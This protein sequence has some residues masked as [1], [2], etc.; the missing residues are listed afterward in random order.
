M[1]AQLDSFL[2]KYN[3]LSK[4][5]HGF[6]TGSSTTT[7]LHEFYERLLEHL[8]LGE[9]PIALLCDL[10]RA[11]DCVDPTTLL[12]TLESIS[13]RGPAL[14][15]FESYLNDR[16]QFVKLTSLQNNIL[17][18]S[19]SEILST[20]L[21]V[22]QGSVLG[23]KL[24]IIYIDGISHFMN[25]KDTT[26]YVDDVTVLKSNKN[27]GQLTVEINSTLQTLNS[28]FNN[29]NLYFNPTKTKYITFHTRQR[30]NI[31]NLEIKLS[32]TQLEQ[33][34]SYKLLG[35]FFDD[36]LTFR[37][38]CDYLRKLLNSICFQIRVL[39]TVFGT[40]ELVNFY[41]A[42]VYSRLVYGITIW[43]TSSAS[44]EIF[45]IQKRIVRTILGAPQTQSCRELFKALN[46][47]PLA[48]ILI[49]EL[50]YYAHTNK[51]KFSKHLDVHSHLTRNREK[52]L[53]PYRR[54]NLSMNEHNILGCRLYN[55]LP[56]EF[57]IIK[58]PVQFR[59]LVTRYLSKISPYTIE[60]YFSYMST[61]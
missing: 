31:P 13:V 36:Q 54:L 12:E 43:G 39:K 15:W 17:Q 3:I 44:A 19:V 22:P 16:S 8:E 51:S 42:Y 60:E 29:N 7:A 4:S 45:L 53:I 47:L 14:K 2:N 1:L 38:H 33:V 55:V 32:D 37:I 27:H 26:L 40:P 28:W 61:E 18:T 5:Q 46:I 10:S 9:C 21:G 59:K 25:E 24:F 49:R 52:L 50:L 56:K 34:S 11:F 58:S 30:T 6:R 20:I 23:P 48:G 41:Y 57:K 35:I